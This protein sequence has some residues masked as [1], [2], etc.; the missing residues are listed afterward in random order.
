MANTDQLV[1]IYVRSETDPKYDPWQLEVYNELEELKSQIRILL[2]TSRGSVLGVP[3]FGL[4]LEDYLFTISAN[5][6]AIRKDIQSQ[7]QAFCYVPDGYSVRV[8]V[9]I[10]GALDGPYNILKIDIYIN[11]K[12]SLS[13]NHNYVGR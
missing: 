10:V 11:N 3:D 13:V 6:E 8:D 2:T 9:N 1:S 5:L 12:Y 7:I 4:N